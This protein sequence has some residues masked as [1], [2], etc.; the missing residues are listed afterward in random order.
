[1]TVESASRRI[2]R[3]EAVVLLVVLL[4]AAVT[5]LGWPGLT[6]FKAD[7]GRLLTLALRMSD[8][9]WAVRG[10]SSSVGFPNAPM[11]V[12]LYSLPLFVR[13]HP[14][15]ATLFTGALGVAAVAGV[16]WIGRRYSGV[17][18]AIAATLMLT[19]GPWAIVFSRKIWA[20]NLLPAVAVAWAISA[21][22]AF[23]DGRRPYV[24]LH[25]LLLAVAAQIHPAAAGLAPA[26][27]LFLIVFRRRV[28][29]W[30]ALLGVALSLLTAAPFLWYLLDRARAAGGLPLSSGQ[31][32]GGVSLQSLRLTLELVAGAGVWPLAGSGYDGLPSEGIVRLAWLGFVVAAIGWA[33]RRLVRQRGEREAD[34]L[35]ICLGWLLS[36]ALLFAWQ[37]TPIHIHYFIVTLPA[38][39]LLAGALFARIVDDAPRGRRAAA[40]SA[41]VVVAAM[42]LASWAGV[43]SAVSRDPTAGGFGVPLGTKVAAADAAR[44]LATEHGA[45][46]VL[47]VGDGA[48]PEQDDFPAEFRAL[49]HGLPVRFVDLNRE[50]VF[51]AS[52]SVLLLDRPAADAPTSTRD[53]YQVVLERVESVGLGAE[54]GYT[55]GMLPGAAAPPSDVML[56][57]PALLANFVRLVGH[58]GPL[59]IAGGIVWDVQ[60]LTADNPDPADYHFFN[61]LLDAAG[62]RVAQSDAAAFAAAQW[63]PDDVVISRF[64]LPRPAEAPRPWTMRVGMYRF[65]SLE[66]VPVLD[67]AANPASDAVEFPLTP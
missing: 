10:I 66:N 45:A 67:E 44:R 13:R 14:Y 41:L 40:W 7:E 27:L 17:T 53:L 47:L 8:G 62:R 57:E 46:E 3:R 37:W 33:V 59:E 64:Y 15:A 58:N 32:S 11:S 9:E 2:S 16:Y 31:A 19:A 39:C 50:A 48:N 54:P 12:W 30:Y 55:V 60:W 25:L 36:P 38:S 51:P 6:E 22:L 65:P 28:S 63:R 18:A 61:H 29:R 52:T 49:L 1:M 42:Q 56:N 23:V 43:M 26:T 21:A 35:L 24:A 4:I 34:Y 5:R 20:Q